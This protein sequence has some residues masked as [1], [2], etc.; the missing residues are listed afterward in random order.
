MWNAGCDVGI[1]TSFLLASLSALPFAFSLGYRAPQ[2]QV[3]Y[4]SSSLCHSALMPIENIYTT[5][6]GNVQIAPR[7]KYLICCGFAQVVL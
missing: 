1:A 5:G 7:T 3:M 6:H 4:L 2:G